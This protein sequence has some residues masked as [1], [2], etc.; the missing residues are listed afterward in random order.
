MIDA[1]VI[2]RATL[3]VGAVLHGPVVLEEAESTVLIGEGGVGRLLES[4][5]VAVELD[6]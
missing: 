1:R 5:C 2:D 4:G 6:A 3:R